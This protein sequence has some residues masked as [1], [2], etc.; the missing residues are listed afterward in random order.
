ME[1]SF[2]KAKSSL[3]LSPSNLSCLCLPEFQF[4]SCPS[5]ESIMLCL[6]SLPVCCCRKFFCKK[7]WNNW[8]IYLI[9]FT[10]LLYHSSIFSI[11]QCLNMH[12][13]FCPVS[14][15]FTVGEQSLLKGPK[16][17]SVGE[18]KK[19]FVNILCF[20]A[21]RAFLATL[22]TTWVKWLNNEHAS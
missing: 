7:S 9:S 10:S 3:S 5:V 18:K 14:W 22:L 17:K 6:S 15:L 13:I 1:L 21:V 8:G 20:C 4:I 2:F 19:C 11:V 12:F 16:W